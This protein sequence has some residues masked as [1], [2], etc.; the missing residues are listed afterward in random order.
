MPDNRPAVYLEGNTVI[1]RASALGHCARSLWAA[2]NNMERR[3]IPDPILKA[4]NE[5]TDLEPHIL[6][7]LYEDHGFTFGDGQ[8]FQV[9]L[10]VGAWNGYT[11]IVR[12][13]MDERGNRYGVTIM[14]PI[15]VKAFAQ[16][17]VDEFRS[18]GF[19]AFPHYAFQQ[20]VYAHGL[21]APA[22]IMPIYNKDTGKIEEWSLG[23]I[24]PI[25]TR[26]QIRDRV[27]EV[28]EAFHSG[29]MPDNCPGDYGC[30]YWYLHDGKDTDDLPD[31]VVPLIRTRIKLSEKIKTLDGARKKLDEAISLK[32][33]QG[34]SYYLDDYTITLIANPD[35][36][37]TV[38]AKQILREAEID[39]EHDEMFILHGEG[40]QLRMTR[41]R[42]KNQ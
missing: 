39:Y 7:L 32:V 36:F 34:V 31:D 29:T 20:S 15:D 25:Y 22:F 2:R 30:Q 14:L 10:N 18:K 1:Y 38:A 9:E 23:P 40:T 21:D 24:P 16:S 17:T 41:K 42:T 28:E 11:L 8:Q 13:K 35:K 6:N 12:G 33:N 27:M 26:D 3:S 37:N 5:G 19:K 4:M